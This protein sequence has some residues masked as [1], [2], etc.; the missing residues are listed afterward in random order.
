MCAIGSFANSG[1]GS[2]I[3]WWS[4]E[5]NRGKRDDRSRIEERETETSQG[6]GWF[7]LLT[8]WYGLGRAILPHYEDASAAQPKGV[9]PTCRKVYS[10]KNVSSSQRA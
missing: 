9:V 1:S 8:M 6:A 4:E 2:D 5:R 7:Y 3:L 10:T